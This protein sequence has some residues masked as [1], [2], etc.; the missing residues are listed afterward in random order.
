LRAVFY[1]MFIDCLCLNLQNPCPACDSGDK[2]VLA[3]ITVLGNSIIK[4]CNLCRRHVISFPALFYWL[5]VDRIIHEYVQKLCCEFNVGEIL[6]KIPQISYLPR[7]MMAAA[8]M[9]SY[10]SKSFAAGVTGV[11]GEGVYAEE[12]LQ[13]DIKSTKEELQEKKINVVNTIKISDVKDPVA[14]VE[15]LKNTLIKP[16]VMKPGDNV[17]LYVDDDGQV[18]HVETSKVDVVAD[19]DV[20]KGLT[21][22]IKIMEKDLQSMK[23]A[24]TLQKNNLDTIVKANKLKKNG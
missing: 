16:S 23:G 14:N 4:I 22:K 10:A 7:R 2:V 24:V 13:K 5:P 12:I 6:Q 21:E 1:Q 15:I 8:Q 18:V 9:S 11:E 20:V 3:R 19:S 17:V